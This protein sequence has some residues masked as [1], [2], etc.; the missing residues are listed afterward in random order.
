[1]DEDTL[2]NDKII[3]HVTDEEIQVIQCSQLNPER[4]EGQL[5]GPLEHIDATLHSPKRYQEEH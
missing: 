1:M 4:L 3:I 2:R 5:Y